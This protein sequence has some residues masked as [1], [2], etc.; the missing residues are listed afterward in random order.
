MSKSEEAVVSM[1]RDLLDEHRH[2]FIDN[3]FCSLRLAIYLLENR[4]TYMT[5]IVAQ[6]RGP[7]LML[8]AVQLQKKSSS[9]V[10]RENYLICKYE[11][12]KTIYSITSK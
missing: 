10:R 11:D 12:R 9:F 3:W 4:Q 7:P 2:V 1:M 5:G 6:G 8:Q